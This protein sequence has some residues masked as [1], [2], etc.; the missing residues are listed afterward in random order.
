M[1]TCR[2]FVHKCLAPPSS[3]VL[4]G[5]EDSVRALHIRSYPCLSGRRVADHVETVVQL[6]KIAIFAKFCYCIRSCLPSIIET[7]H[8]IPDDFSPETCERF[9]IARVMSIRLPNGFV[10][11]DDPASCTLERGEGVLHRVISPDC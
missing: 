9:V 8:Q 6:V 10:I 7:F 4:Q 3:S 1:L 2:Q 11:F 5:I